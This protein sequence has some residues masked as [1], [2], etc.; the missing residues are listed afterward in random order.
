MVEEQYYRRLLRWYPRSW[1][2]YHGEALLGIMLDE[3]EA[4]GRSRPTV[5]QRWSAF[6]HGTGN[7]LGARAALWCAAIG[8]VLSL[9]SLALLFIAIPTESQG[10][11]TIFSWIDQAMRT[12][13]GAVIAAGYLGLARERGVLP[14]P[15]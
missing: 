10:K 8:L 11:D 14:A 2:A 1:R 15:R 12:L 5:G 4:L 9:V 6:L 7:R 3:A 13:P